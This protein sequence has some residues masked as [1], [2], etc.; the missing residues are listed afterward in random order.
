MEMFAAGRGGDHPSLVRPR[1][2]ATG[3]R[4]RFKAPKDVVP[5]E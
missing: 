4:G 5:E 3:K 2:C 1:C